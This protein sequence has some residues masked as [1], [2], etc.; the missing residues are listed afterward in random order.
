VQST[1]PTTHL[2]AGP[3]NLSGGS[4]WSGPRP[5]GRV[6]AQHAQC[7]SPRAAGSR[8]RPCGGSHAGARER[9]VALRRDSSPLSLCLRVAAAQARMPR[10]KPARRP[11]RYGSAPRDHSS[12]CAVQRA[13][14]ACSVVRQY[15]RTRA[16]LC[17]SRHHLIQ[18]ICKKRALAANRTTSQKRDALSNQI[19]FTTQQARSRNP[20]PPGHGM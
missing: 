15:T 17:G 18:T 3:S 19:N 14:F 1:N 16:R 2:G 11:Q 10:T 7:A 12:I 13:A 20:A 8:P 6:A 5:R 9:L 4:D